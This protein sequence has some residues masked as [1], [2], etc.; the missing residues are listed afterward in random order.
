MGFKGIC[1]GAESKCTSQKNICSK[2]NNEKWCERHCKCPENVLEK[3]HPTLLKTPNQPRLAKG[4]A[5]REISDNVQRELFTPEA[6]KATPA[7]KRQKDSEV[8]TLEGLFECFPP[9]GDVRNIPSEKTRFASNAEELI[10]QAN[11]NAQNNTVNF[12][13]E[14]LERCAQI[15]LPTAFTYIM[16]VAATRIWEKW[17]KIFSQNSSK[18]ERSLEKM[19]NSLFAIATALPSKSIAV[20]TTRAVIVTACSQKN[21]DDNFYEY[22]PPRYGEKARKNGHADYSRMVT[23][24]KTPL[25]VKRK[26]ARVPNAIVSDM[27]DFILLPLNVGTL[28][29]GKNEVLIPNT[30]TTIVLPKLTRKRPVEAMWEHYLH[31]SYSRAE[32][33]LL[34]ASMTTTRSQS[35]SRSVENQREHIGRTTFIAA[36]RAITADAE[37]MMQSV[38]YICDALVN[39]VVEM[40]QRIS[41]DLVAPT[42]KKHIS[43][44]IAIVRNFLKVQ[45]DQHASIEDDKVSSTLLRIHPP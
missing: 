14:I 26:L 12:L 28:S 2:C 29:W 4:R 40:L 18:R 43:Q 1:I 20:R 44:L 3:K 10:V 15:I 11:R 13:L 16:G 24:G 38:D 8:T 25:V 35:K 33:D 45:Y 37:N 19:A 32:M 34:S 7:T 17:N 5:L 21:L 6:M 41:S 36:A 9:H 39:V 31:I 30:S 23:E 42:L 27:V 22:G